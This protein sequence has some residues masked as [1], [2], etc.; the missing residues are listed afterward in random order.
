MI[1][2]N[3]RKSDLVDAECLARVARLDPTLLAP[4]EHRGLACQADLALLRSRGCLV[5]ART[6][7]VNH[8]RATV[9]GFGCR[10]PKCNTRSFG[11]RFDEKVPEPLRPALQP[12]ID[13]ICE[14]NLKIRR[15]ERQIEEMADQRYPESALLRQVAGV[16]ALTSMAYI[17]TIEDP[18]RFKRSRAVGSYVGLR[19]RQD[20]S[21]QRSP[22]LRITKAGDAD[23]RRLL[24]TSAHYIIGPFGPDSDLRRRGLALAARGGKNAKK[25]AVVAVARKLAVLLHHLWI[26]GEVYEPLRTS[27]AKEQHNPAAA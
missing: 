3:D 5:R 21:G 13:L 8:V 25:R 9:K 22:Q 19:P 10:L 23:L 1:Y 17:L 24:V 11:K 14:L 20:D 16:G 12:H 27:T 18:S 2:Q 7:L 15:Y 4:I 6:Q 26:T